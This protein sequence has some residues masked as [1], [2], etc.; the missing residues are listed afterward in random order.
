MHFSRSLPNLMIYLIHTGYW[1][2]PSCNVLALH[3]QRI[4]EFGLH[5]VLHLILYNNCNR[6]GCMD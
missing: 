2:Q 4:Q 5:N 3:F 1:T 6:L